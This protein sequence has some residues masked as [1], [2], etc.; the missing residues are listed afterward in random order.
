MERDMLQTIVERGLRIDALEAE[1]KY[2][3]FYVKN[4]QPC[5]GAGD[6]DINNSI[7]EEF[8]RLFGVNALPAKERQYYLERQAERRREE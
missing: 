5:L 8:V 3:R 6:G 1:V 4:V 2:L 7:G